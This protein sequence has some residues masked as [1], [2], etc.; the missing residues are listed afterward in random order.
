MQLNFPWTHTH[1]VAAHKSADAGAWTDACKSGS[2]HAQYFMLWT[3]NS[4]SLF[5]KNF[6]WLLRLFEERCTWNHLLKVLEKHQVEVHRLLR[7]LHPSLTKYVANQLWRFAVSFHYNPQI[8]RF[9]FEIWSILTP[10][11]KSD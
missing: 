11:Y 4:T 7:S 3:D 5:S 8:Q 2:K 6:P 1:R 9:N 10:S